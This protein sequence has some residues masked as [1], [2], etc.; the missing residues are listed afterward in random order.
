[1]KI[2]SQGIL[3]MLINK[4]MLKEINTILPIFRA[5]GAQKQ[6]NYKLITINIISKSTP[7][8]FDYSA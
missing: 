3:K 2:R 8:C 6:V 1:V 4:L 7:T 5:A